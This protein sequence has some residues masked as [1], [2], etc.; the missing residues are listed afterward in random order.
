MYEKNK[1]NPM[2]LVARGIFALRI[3]AQPREK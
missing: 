1:I 3:L 2:R